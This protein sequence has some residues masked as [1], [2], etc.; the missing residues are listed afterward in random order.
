MDDK[1]IENLLRDSCT[2]SVPEGMRDR[3]LRRSRQELASGRRAKSPIFMFS[4][5]SAL[6]SL[7]L[8]VILGTN[9]SEYARQCR[10]AVMLGGNGSASQVKPLELQEQRK[11]MG[12]LMAMSSDAGEA[13]ISRETP[14]THRP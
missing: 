8:L 5:K 13:E 1:H 7:A 14:S 4:W 2:T 6:V 12:E 9:V 11:L 3:V 10:F